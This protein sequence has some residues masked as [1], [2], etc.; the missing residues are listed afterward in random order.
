MNIL[1]Q[2]KKRKLVEE[3]GPYMNKRWAIYDNQDILE[4]WFS[5]KQKALSHWEK[6]RNAETWAEKRERYR[7]ELIAN[8]EKHPDLDELPFM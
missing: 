2:N 7:Q 1:L 4:V 6:Y 8:I 3:Y 5:D